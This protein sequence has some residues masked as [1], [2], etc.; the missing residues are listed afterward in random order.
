M[1][2]R[3]KEKRTRP[4]WERMALIDRR[5][6]LGAY[7]NCVR[8]ARELEG[9]PKTLKRD[10]AFMRDRLRLPIEYDSRSHGFFYPLPRGGT[11]SRESP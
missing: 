1:H 10:V 3:A 4:P 9:S 11:R 8:L 7:P 5:I 2:A 6:Q